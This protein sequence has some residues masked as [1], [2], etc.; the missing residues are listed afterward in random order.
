[1]WQEGESFVFRPFRITAA[2]T[3]SFHVGCFALSLA[4]SLARFFA[5]ETG[6]GADYRSSEVQ[7]TG[8]SVV[9]VASEIP[10]WV[11]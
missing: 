8:K 4:G 10:F 1:V 11:E 6:S 3:A 5:E 9:V 7:W 2:V